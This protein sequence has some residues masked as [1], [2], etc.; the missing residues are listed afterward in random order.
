[1]SVVRLAGELAVADRESLEVG[2]GLDAARFRE[3]LGRRR[4]GG[5]VEP[6]L[7]S[8]KLALGF[9]GSAGDRFGLEEIDEADGAARF[10]GFAAAG[11]KSRHAMSPSA[12]R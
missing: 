4:R 11:G 2:A 3:L 10:G 5:A 1:M 8:G 7:D 6:P 12:S 9:R